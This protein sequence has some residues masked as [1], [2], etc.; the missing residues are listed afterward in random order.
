MRPG[1]ELPWETSPSLSFAR[2]TVQVIIVPECSAG[3][4]NVKP[5]SGRNITRIIGISAF[6][7]PF[8][9]RLAD[10]RT[11]QGEF[12]DRPSDWST[13]AQTVHPGQCRYPRVHLAG[14]HRRGAPGNHLWRVIA[15]LVTQS[16]HDG[17]GI[18]ADRR[19][20]N[21]PL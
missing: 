4:E 11:D 20:V 18:G 16:G 3:K 10:G 21:H 13:G 5:P 19:A 6:A 15:L 14:S 2:L 12:A 7:R 1:V 8:S 9:W 17:F